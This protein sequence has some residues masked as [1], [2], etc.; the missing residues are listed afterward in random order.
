MTLVDLQQEQ[1]VTYVVINRK[2]V[3]LFLQQ[4][5]AHPD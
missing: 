4:S 2:I 5:L 3:L 1:E